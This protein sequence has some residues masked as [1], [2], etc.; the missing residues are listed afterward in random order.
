V[1]S[2]RADM[3]VIAVTGGAGSCA[4]PM[5]Y[6]PDGVVPSF[7]PTPSSSNALSM[8]TGAHDHDLSVMDLESNAR[9]SARIG[10]GNSRRQTLD[11]QR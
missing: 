6:G 11:Y 9:I 8:P 2:D 5:P 1:V 7:L 4:P 3:V 10:D